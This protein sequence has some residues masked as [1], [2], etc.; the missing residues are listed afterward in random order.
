MQPEELRKLL[1]GTDQEAAAAIRRAV[2]ERRRDL[3]PPIVERLSQPASPLLRALL[4]RALGYL[5]SKED[6]RWV[7]P[8]I[9]AT[10]PQV[11]L[12]ALKALARLRFPGTVP[13]LVKLTVTDPDGTVKTAALAILKSVA[14]AILQDHL[15]RMLRSAHEW[16]RRASVRYAATILGPEGVPLL[17]QAQ[18]STDALVRAYAEQWLEQL[19]PEQL[20]PELRAVA[21][22]QTPAPEPPPEPLTPQA[23]QAPE[24]ETPA[25]PVAVPERRQLPAEAQ[26]SPV[27]TASPI[28]WD[29]FLGDP[30]ASIDSR[31]RLPALA[32]DMNVQSG[33]MVLAPATREALAAA[34]QAPATPAAQASQPP[35][36]A[37]PAAQASQAPVPVSTDAGMAAPA[38]PSVRAPG[39]EC[40]V[41]SV[42]SRKQVAARPLQ[43][44]AVCGEDLPA[45]S[46][47]CPACGDLR[48]KPPS[49]PANVAAR[50]HAGPPAP[51]WLLGVFSL[52]A[53][54]AVVGLSMPLIADGGAQGWVV[55]LL[56]VARLAAGLD[57]LRGKS[58]SWVVLAALQVNELRTFEIVNVCVSALVLGLL[59]LPAVR[60]WCVR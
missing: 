6:A 55:A 26:A 39:P 27:G 32:P 9:E 2:D 23:I 37:T 21:K 56:G 16:V 42:P 4:L 43:Q 50:P 8:S 53:A 36:P 17:R 25:A 1:S 13:V 49:R 3:L 12:E 30:L 19:E 20:E 45:A 51:V 57:L 24:P 5:G 44:C 18:G 54:L 34:V 48:V 52:A 28:A 7:A 58:W 40:P 38:G 47:R 11:R 59:G 15:G 35:V 31:S 33:V 46:T 22:E 60:A 14:P 41:R 29:N 10:E